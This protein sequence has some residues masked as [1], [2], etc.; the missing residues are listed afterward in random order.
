MVARLA[1][2]GLV[3]LAAL[4][5]AAPSNSS[6]LV[7]RDAHHLKLEVNWRG[8]A[9]LSYERAGGQRH[10]LLWGA[11]GALARL[12]VDY[13]GGKQR[14]H[15]AYWRHFAGTCGHYDGPHLSYLVS[16]CKAP[17]GSYW[18]VQS[19]PPPANHSWFEVS[20][21]RGAVAKVQLG[22]AWA[23]DGRFQ[24]IFGRLTYETQPAL[25]YMTTLNTFISSFGPGWRIQDSFLTRRATGAFCYGLWPHRTNGAEFPGTGEKYRVALS[26]PGVTPLVSVTL[27]GFHDF[28][29]VSGRDAVH[30]ERAATRLRSWGVTAS[31]RDCG[32]VL[33]MAAKIAGRS[34]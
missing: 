23:Y 20:H 11:T 15:Q 32:P 7:A 28:D 22:R 29:P 13:T 30:Q 5:L 26:G 34:G 16:A 24:L 3:V 17:D 2:L 6:Q 4:A 18:A 21:W 14:Y 19:L 10:V 9:L 33:R 1:A 25:D 8:E 12:Q 27:P 31:D